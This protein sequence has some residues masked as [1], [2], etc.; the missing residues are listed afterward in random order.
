MRSTAV[1]VHHK[2]HLCSNLSLCKYIL[3]N[4]SHSSHSCSSQGC[5]NLPTA[6]G[7]PTIVRIFEASREQVRTPLRFSRPTEPERTVGSFEHVEWR[8]I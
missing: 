4:D 2:R 5:L 7:G 6:A 1:L 3:K 8:P